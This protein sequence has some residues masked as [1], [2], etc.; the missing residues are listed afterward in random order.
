MRSRAQDPL[1]L[2]L[3]EI[4][5]A[6][7]MAEKVM[8]REYPVGS[9]CSYTHGEQRR[10]CVVLDHGYGLRIRVRHRGSGAV[11]IVG[12]ERLEHDD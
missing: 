1:R 7:V 12:A 9:L 11:V 10:H 8:R 2:A 5:R 6:E 3:D 4:R